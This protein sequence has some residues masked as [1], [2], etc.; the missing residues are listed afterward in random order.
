MILAQ[1]NQTKS[2]RRKRTIR[3]DSQALSQDICH[4]REAKRYAAI[5]IPWQVPMYSGMQTN[6]PTNGGDNLYLARYLRPV[7]LEAGIPSFSR[8]ARFCFLFFILGDVST[9]WLLLHRSHLNFRKP[10]LAMVRRPSHQANQYGS[11]AESS[12]QTQNVLIG[13]VEGCL[14]FDRARAVSLEPNTICNN[15]GAVSSLCFCFVGMLRLCRG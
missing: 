4:G 6:G 9:H 10:D 13:W 2:N 14:R 11:A 15:D 5:D 12:G 7:S 1:I 3:S 8:C